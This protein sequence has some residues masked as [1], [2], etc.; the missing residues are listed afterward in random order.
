MIPRLVRGIQA[1]IVFT[2]GRT[3]APIPADAQS[4]EAKGAFI[5]TPDAQS[6]EQQISIYRVE[7]AGLD[8]QWAR[9][10]FWH[11]VNFCPRFEAF[12]DAL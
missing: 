1:N 2:V 3:D 9:R 4:G 8:D 6:A 11:A 7:L 12:S 5:P 10:Q